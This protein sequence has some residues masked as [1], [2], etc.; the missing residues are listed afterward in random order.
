MHFDWFNRLALF[1]AG[2]LGAGGMAAAA[3][4]THSGAP[5]LA[6]L[7]L[8]ALTPAPVLLVFG[9]VPFTAIRPRT[10]ALILGA[11]AILFTADL[12]VRHVWGTAL[13]PYAAPV[14]G[15]AMI[16]GWATMGISSIVP[17]GRSGSLQRG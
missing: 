3:A 1:V 12:A 2:V 17:W 13:F 14:G 16:I 10:G 11:G 8:I 5:M 4:A 7:S 9:L 6:P 15:S